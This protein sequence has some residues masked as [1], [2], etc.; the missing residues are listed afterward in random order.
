MDKE[1]YEDEFVKILEELLAYIIFYYNFK[2]NSKTKKYYDEINKDEINKDKK[3]DKINEII[4]LF[5]KKL[6]RNNVN[7]D[8]FK[9]KINIII[10]KFKIFTRK[11]KSEK[12][13]IN[14]YY[15]EIKPV[16]P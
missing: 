15:I 16:L 13:K 14:G 9:N 10:D 6:E 2:Y 7:Y 3:Q 1:K 5:K 11:G 12:N 4:S 8:T